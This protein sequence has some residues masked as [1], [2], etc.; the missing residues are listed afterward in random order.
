M[1]IFIT[2]L[3]KRT[4]ELG[5]YNYDAVAALIVLKDGH[6][7]QMIRWNSHG[8]FRW[9]IKCSVAP[10]SKWNDIQNHCI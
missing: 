9:R 3:D 8:W 4:V 5:G 10:I 7:R 6:G 1:G 2:D